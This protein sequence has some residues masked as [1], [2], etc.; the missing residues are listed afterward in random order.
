LTQRKSSTFQT[1]ENLKLKKAFTS[2]RGE[3]C[4]MGS[5][6]GKNQGRKTTERKKKKTAVASEKIKEGKLNRSGEK[7]ETAERSCPGERGRERS[8]TNLGSPESKDTVLV[9]HQ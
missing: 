9:Y 1:Q 3:R 8:G 7:Y 2:L 5:E 4:F 6:G